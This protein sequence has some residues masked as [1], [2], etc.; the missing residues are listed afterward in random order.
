VNAALREYLNMGVVRLPACAAS[1]VLTVLCAVPP[2]AAQ[3]VMC[4][5]PNVSPKVVTAPSVQVPPIANAQG[6][7]GE[8]QVLVSLNENSQIVGTPVIRKSPSA[9]LN[10][11]AINVAMHSTFQTEIKN[12]QPII[13]QYTLLVE[14]V[15]S[16]TPAPVA[17]NPP[18]PP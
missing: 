6:I 5:V 1:I 3:Q 15:A 10:K 11:E 12:C 14:F 7:S 13:A 16:K 8:V 17:T 18:N 4:A 2:V 9:L